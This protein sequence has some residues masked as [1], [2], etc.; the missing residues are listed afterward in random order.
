MSNLNH[1]HGRLTDNNNN[2]NRCKNDNHIGNN[3]IGKNVIGKN[4]TSK[5]YHDLCNYRCLCHYHLILI[6]L[7]SRDFCYAST[8]TYFIDV[9]RIMVRNTE[10]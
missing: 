5:K 6:P 8:T 2:G 4:A 1:G 9:V 10:K 7:I 3:D